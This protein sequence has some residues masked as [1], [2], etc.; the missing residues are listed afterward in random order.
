MKGSVY[1]NAT[2]LGIKG[3]RTTAKISWMVNVR[4]CSS[5]FYADLTVQAEPCCHLDQ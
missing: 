1:W 5:T 4:N 3:I 2:G